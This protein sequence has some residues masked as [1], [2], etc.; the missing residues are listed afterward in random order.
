MTDDRK[1]TRE[2]LTT[3]FGWVAGGALALLLNFGL[4][5]A[6]GEA[7]RDNDSPQY[8]DACFTTQYPTRLTDHDGADNVRTRLASCAVAVLAAA[9]RR[10]GAAAAAE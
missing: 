7:A 6:V 4:Y 5:R 1:G 9:A 3:A 2:R 8:C 10:R